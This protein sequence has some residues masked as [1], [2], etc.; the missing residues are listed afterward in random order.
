[1]ASAAAVDRYKLQIEELEKKLADVSMAFQI[2]SFLLSS[3]SFNFVGKITWWA[4]ETAKLGEILFTFY[5]ENTKGFS[6]HQ[7]LSLYKHII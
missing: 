6:S 2:A 4:D 1:L 3:F 7:Y 5:G